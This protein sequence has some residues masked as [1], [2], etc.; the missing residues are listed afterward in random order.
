MKRRI[1]ITIITLAL[2]SLGAQGAARAADVPEYF[3]IDHID[4]RGPACPPE[5]AEVQL[6]GD[7]TRFIVVFD[8]FNVQAGPGIPL[9]EASK[10]CNLVVYPIYPSGWT[11]SIASIAYR[12]NAIL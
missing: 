10:H 12:G 7:N 3:R 5:T 9:T 6:V 2:G 11:W 4:Y 8:S 1:G